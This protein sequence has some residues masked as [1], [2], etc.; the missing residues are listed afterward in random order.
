MTRRLIFPRVL[1]LSEDAL[2]LPN[3]CF[4]V[5]QECFGFGSVVSA[6]FFFPGSSCCSVEGRLRQR[7]G[8]SRSHCLSVFFSLR[9]TGLRLR[10]QFTP[11]KSVSLTM[12]YPNFSASKRWIITMVSFPVGTL[13][14]GNMKGASFSS[15]Y[16]DGRMVSGPWPCLKQTFAI[17][18]CKSYTKNR[19]RR[20][21]V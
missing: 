2:L 19:F 14:K 3:R 5:W 9:S 10:I 11:L 4:S 16:C 18:S 21:R 6:S 17:G 1:V 13:S 15:C 20:F 12:E 8:T 7:W